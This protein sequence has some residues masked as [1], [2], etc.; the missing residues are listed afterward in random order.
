M[1][2][3]KIERR[4]LDALIAE[5]NRLCEGLVGDYEKA[6]TDIVVYLRTSNMVAEEV[7][8]CVGDVLDM[9]IE[10]QGKG[11]P[12]EA[13]VGDDVEAFCHEIS[14]AVGKPRIKDRVVDRF[15]ILI[16]SLQVALFFAWFN[17]I[18][19]KDGFVR[20]VTIIKVTP[21]V[22]INIVLMVCTAFIIIHIFHRNLFKEGKGADRILFAQFF[23]V[24]LTLIVSMVGLSYVMEQWVLFEMHVV[25]L[26]M[27]MG[28]I[29][30]LYTFYFGRLPRKHPR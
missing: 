1:E 16:P 21:A 5:H 19:L 9:L 24:F 23:A 12:V 20:G 27:A 2:N 10:G 18:H 28:V 22:L 29:W 3:S 6:Y 26:L 17:N 25:W 14:A 11:L 13:I 4:G 7:E 8:S 15:R 30:A